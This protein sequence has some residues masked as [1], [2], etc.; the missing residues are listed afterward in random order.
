M[1]VKIL[2]NIKLQLNSG[3]DLSIKN[4]YTCKKNW[5]TNVNGYQ[6]NRSW[7]YRTENKI[8]RGIY[9]KCNVERENVE[10]KTVM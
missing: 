6:E 8:R 7:C 9:N 5:K 10:K 2:K 1:P 4:V 3:P